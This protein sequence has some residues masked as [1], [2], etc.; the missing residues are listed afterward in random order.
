MAH[1]LFPANAK[2]YDVLRAF[3][4][5]ETYWPANT[6]VA[7]GDMVYIYLAAPYRQVGFV[8]KATE[9]GLDQERVLPRVRPFFKQPNK[10]KNKPKGFIKLRTT[11]AISLDPDSP[12]SYRHLK[13][14]GL[15]GMLMGPRRLENNPQ[16]L[17]YIT[18]V[19]R[20]L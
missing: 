3:G 9:V 13:Q 4:E 5:P 7:V 19:C 15:S 8:C 11:A 1:W 6:T 18:G 16:L 2:R 20:E 10:P 12:L 14:N 17:E